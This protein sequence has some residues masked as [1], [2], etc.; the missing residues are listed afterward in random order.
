MPLA[1][2][3]VTAQARRPLGPDMA[4]PVAFDE[5]APGR[6]LATATLPALGQWELRLT[7]QRLGQTLHA[8]RRIVAK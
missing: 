2:A 3:T 4:T 8:T 7:V 1:H 5:V 6:Y